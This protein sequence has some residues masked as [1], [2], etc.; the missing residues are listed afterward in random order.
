MITMM[1]MVDADD[2]HKTAP[3]RL[4]G[5]CKSGGTRKGG[6]C[7]RWEGGTPPSD[8]KWLPPGTL[9]ASL[10]TGTVTW[11]LP[12]ALWGTADWPG[13]TALVCGA[14]RDNDGHPTPYQ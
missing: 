12:S 2:A 14:L 4:G 6:C 13:M 3:A 5:T 9:R 8:T 11:W 10:V 7:N 1:M